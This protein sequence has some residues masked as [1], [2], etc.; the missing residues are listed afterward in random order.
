V[1]FYPE[2][3]EVAKAKGTIRPGFDQA[4]AHEP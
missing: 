4:A 3:L 2:L 1:Q